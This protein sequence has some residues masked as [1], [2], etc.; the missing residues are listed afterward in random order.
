MSV[1]ETM[2]VVELVRRGLIS[3]DEAR[4]MLGFAEKVTPPVLT[5]NHTNFLGESYIPAW[6]SDWSFT[7]DTVTVTNTT[8]PNGSSNSPAPVDFEKWKEDF[9]A[10]F[11][12]EKALP[13]SD[14]EP[15]ILPLHAKRKITLET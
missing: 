7:V 13:K 14:P 10:Q 4:R 2:K 6:P 8:V 15:E 3:T 12:R 11:I 9:G 5:T 1:E